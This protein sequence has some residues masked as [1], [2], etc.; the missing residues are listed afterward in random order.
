MLGFGP[1]DGNFYR[2]GLYY[3]FEYW[4]VI[5]NTHDSL[6]ADIVGLDDLLMEHLTFE[7]GNI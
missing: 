3:K 7:D 4:S 5:G 2:F 6:A 1:F